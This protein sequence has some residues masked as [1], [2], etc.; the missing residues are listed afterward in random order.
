M[1]FDKS[2]FDSFDKDWALVTAGTAGDF[3]TMTV[4]WGGL[5][6]LWNLPVATVYIRKTRYTHDFLEKNG[7]FTVSFFSEAYRKD[8]DILGS[9]S[10]RDCD[11]LALTSLT[12][13]ALDGAVTFEQAERTILCRKIYC[14][15]MDPKAI[16]A[17]IYAKYYGKES[18]HTI[19]IGEV[20]QIL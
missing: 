15:N 12:P 20:L 13:K 8:L 3:N 4:S 9:K 14:Q 7:L 17:E 5:G 6:T 18:L 16:P 11:K 19:Y 2:I 1:G 10:G